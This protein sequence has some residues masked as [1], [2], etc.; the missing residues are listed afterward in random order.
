M[1]SYIH[2]KPTLLVDSLFELASWDSTLSE[3]CPPKRF[4]GDGMYFD[5]DNDSIVIIEWRLGRLKSPYA[6]LGNCY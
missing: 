2:L 1:D 5:V 6:Y 4:S 3:G